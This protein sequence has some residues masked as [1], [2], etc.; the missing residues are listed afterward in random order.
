MQRP[1]S[2]L[3]H[4]TKMGLVRL[5]QDKEKSGWECISPIQM[6]ATHNKNYKRYGNRFEFE[7]TDS[8]FYY[9]AIYRKK[10]I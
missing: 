3:R 6:S 4:K 8:D 5:C 1:T 9:E 10:V 7:D 2:R